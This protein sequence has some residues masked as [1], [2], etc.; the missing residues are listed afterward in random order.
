MGEGDLPSDA[1][2][3]VTDTYLDEKPQTSGKCK[4]AAGWC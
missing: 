3:Q 4:R 1:V 2:E